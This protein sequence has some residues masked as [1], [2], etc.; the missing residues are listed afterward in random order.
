[1][2]NSTPASRLGI[3]EKTIVV[4]AIGNI[5]VLVISSQSG[6]IHKSVTT[7]RGDKKNAIRL[8]N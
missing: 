7:A 4:A 6:L 8:P 5:F 2:P 3:P 1:M